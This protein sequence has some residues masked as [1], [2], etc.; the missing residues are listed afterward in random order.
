MEGLWI[1][2]F[3]RLCFFLRFRM[4]MVKMW[5]QRW[6]G[7]REKEGDW[8]REREDEEKRGGI[9]EIVNAQDRNRN[10]PKWSIEIS[11]TAHAE[12][13]HLIVIFWSQFFPATDVA[14]RHWKLVFN[15]QH[16][17]HPVISPGNAFASRLSTLT[18]GEEF[19]IE[20]NAQAMTLFPLKKLT[21]NFCCSKFEVRTNTALQ[22]RIACRN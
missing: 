22:S 14:W 10:A 18:T 4:L 3:W 12:V 19:R 16:Q 13:L 6:E 17:C 5:D 15:M 11:I 7:R 20:F 8:W 1:C 2:G 9:F 21:V